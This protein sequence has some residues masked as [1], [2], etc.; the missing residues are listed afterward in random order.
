MATPT[1]DW[2]AALRGDAADR[3][4]AIQ[5]MQDQLA[6]LVGEATGPEGRVRVR[7]TPAGAP[8]DLA[9]ADEA[10]RLDAAD[11]AAE[12]L[13][14]LA[15][16]TAEVGERM[17]RVLGDVVPPE[18][19]DAMMTGRPTESDRHDVRAQLDALRAGGHDG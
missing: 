16:A 2:S 8:L 14:V 11:L 10:M 7:V 17:R 1:E 13:A 19:L 5:R 3:L 18:Q 4:E 9:I 12:I 15:T 6:D